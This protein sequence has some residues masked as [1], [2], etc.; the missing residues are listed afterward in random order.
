MMILWV[1]VVILS[2]NDDSCCCLLYTEEQTCIPEFV[3]FKCKEPTSSN[4]MS[5][6]VLDFKT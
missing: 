5:I 4:C 6:P 2:E 3:E 1:L